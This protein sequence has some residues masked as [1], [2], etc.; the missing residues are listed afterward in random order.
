MSPCDPLIDEENSSLNGSSQIFCD[1]T[2]ALDEVEDFSSEN[3]SFCDQT[4]VPDEGE[5]ISM[6]SKSTPQSTVPDEFENLSVNKSTQSLCE[7]FF[8]ENECLCH[9]CPDL[10]EIEPVLSMHPLLYEALS[11]RDLTS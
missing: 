11:S 5:D 4:M 6:E 2:M 10:L 8:L 3:E 9:S 1:H 7:D